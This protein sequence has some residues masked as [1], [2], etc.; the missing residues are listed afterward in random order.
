MD[1]FGLKSSVM[2]YLVSHE[3]FYKHSVLNLLVSHEIFYKHSAF[4][5]EFFG[6]F[7]IEFF[8]LT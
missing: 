6:E 2:N 8:A 1:I 5:T 7:S 4:S 3:I